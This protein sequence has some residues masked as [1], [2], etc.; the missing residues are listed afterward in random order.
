MRMPQRRYLDTAKAQE[1]NKFHGTATTAEDSIR[2]SKNSFAM[3]SVIREEHDSG[4]FD[5]RMKQID[6]YLSDRIQM[7][8]YVFIVYGSWWIIFKECYP[9]ISQ[10]DN[11]PDYHKSVGYIVFFMCVTS[12]RLACTIQPGNITKDTIQ[13]F[14]NY[15][16]DNL[17]YKERICPTLQIRKLPRSKFNR[18]T[19]LH[20]PRFDHHCGKFVEHWH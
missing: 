3:N 17:I 13:R 15:P 16:Y 20:V 6:Q 9:L 10:S 11:V 19:G 12:W 5:T 14:D 1:T 4:T 2:Y 7:F 18:K 8:V